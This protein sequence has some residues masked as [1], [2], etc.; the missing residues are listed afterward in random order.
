MKREMLQ[1]QFAAHEEPRNGFVL[2]GS[3]SPD[4][5]IDKIVTLYFS[6]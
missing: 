3:A 5:M 4:E 1:S 6:S 2:D